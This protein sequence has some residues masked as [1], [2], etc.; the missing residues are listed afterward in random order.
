MILD[1]IVH[2]VRI[3]WLIISV[4]N[5]FKVEY[6]IFFNTYNKMY[7]LELIQWLVSYYKLYPDCVHAS[8]QDD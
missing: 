5:G 3:I 7:A 1:Y 4:M 2:F 6:V 8:C